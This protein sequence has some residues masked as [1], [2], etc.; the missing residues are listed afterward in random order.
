MNDALGG[1]IRGFLKRRGRR[2]DLCGYPIPGQRVCDCYSSDEG[3]GWLEVEN[4]NRHY[5]YSKSD[6]HE[7]QKRF[8]A[9]SSP[10]RVHAVYFE[11]PVVVSDTSQGL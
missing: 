8:L 7:K 2:T 11:T 6:D 1:S 5:L 10:S 9:S 4:R 3:L